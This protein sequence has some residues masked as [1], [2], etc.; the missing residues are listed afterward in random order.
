MFRNSKYHKFDLQN[1]KEYNAVKPFIED[2]LILINGFHK[3]DAAF[4]GVIHTFLVSEDF[5]QTWNEEEIP[6]SMI[7]E[8][9]DLKE[10]K[11][12]T[13]GRIGRF[14]EKK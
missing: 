10:G 7:T 14:Q 2:S 1:F 5:C 11:I 4:L 9:E 6:S 8:T 12:L 13:Y 3:D